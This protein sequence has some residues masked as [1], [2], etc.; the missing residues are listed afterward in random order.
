MKA[1]LY[2]NLVV[3]SGEESRR[4]QESIFDPF[5]TTKDKGSGLGLAIC[6]QIVVE[7]GGFMTVKVP[8]DGS[9]FHVSLPAAPK[10][11]GD[12][13]KY[14]GAAAPSLLDRRQ[15]AKP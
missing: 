8:K 12:G 13:S 9:T 7:T 10:S 4:D 1:K 3:D 2:R 6:H 14:V 15:Y 5:F 11:V